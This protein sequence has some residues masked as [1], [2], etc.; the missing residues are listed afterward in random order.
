[1]YKHN[2]TDWIEVDKHLNDSYTYNTAYV[3]HLIEKIA[4]GEYDPDLL[5]E[6]ESEQVALRLQQ[7]EHE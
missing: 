2:G 6:S 1:V 5:S 3:D 7:R 4:R